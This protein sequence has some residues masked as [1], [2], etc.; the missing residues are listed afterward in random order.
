MKITWSQLQTFKTPKIEL[1]SLSL[2]SSNI[3]YLVFRSLQV[4]SLMTDCNFFCLGYSFSLQPVYGA[5]SL[6]RLQLKCYMLPLLLKYHCYYLPLQLSSLSSCCF[7]LAK[8]HSLETINPICLSTT[9]HCLLSSNF[10]VVA[11]HHS[12][13]CFVIYLCS[14]YLLQWAISFGHVNGNVNS[15][16]FIK[17]AKKKTGYVYSKKQGMCSH[18]LC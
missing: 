16:H 6:F 17:K 11:R 5:C 12:C 4:F 7:A 14:L 15:S 10:L 1:L 13:N 2:T 8:G 9:F 18:V 3:T